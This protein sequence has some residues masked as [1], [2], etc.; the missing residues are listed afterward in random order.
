MGH[1]ILPPPRLLLWRGVL[2]WR[3]GEDGAA[4]A[5]AA[6]HHGER[7]GYHHEEHRAPCGELGEQVGRAARAKGRLR[8]LA[9]EGPGEIGGFALLQQNNADQKQADDDVN[10]YQKDEHGD[11]FESLEIQV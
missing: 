3:P 8:A 10:H 7:D 4:D 2:G 11:I 1:P 9:A 5:R 6:Q